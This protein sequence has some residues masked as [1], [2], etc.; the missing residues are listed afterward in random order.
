LHAMQA[1]YQLSYTPAQ[2]RNGSIASLVF[3]CKA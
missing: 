2:N 1:L 3:A